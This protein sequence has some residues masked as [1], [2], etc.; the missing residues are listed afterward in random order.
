MTS[1]AATLFQSRMK[2]LRLW[3]EVVDH[4]NRLALVKVPAKKKNSYIVSARKIAK[5]ATTLGTALSVVPFEGAYLYICAEYELAVRTLIEDF[6]VSVNHKVKRFADLPDKLKNRNLINS[7]II[8]NELEHDRF[9]T[10][11]LDRFDIVQKLFKCLDAATPDYGFE[12]CEEALSYTRRNFTWREVR[13]LFKELGISNL[14]DSVCA[15]K[16]VQRALGVSTTAHAQGSLPLALD[17]VMFTR[18]RI[19]HRT[20]TVATP[21]ASDVKRVSILLPA[22]VSA[23]DKALQARYKTL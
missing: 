22:I 10:A 14:S 9:A 11:G 8:M 17:Q 5:S 6:G 7:A 13:D 3:L 1:T 23:L 21:S 12:L 18:N 15:V 4:V 19:I 2:S 16:S 20:G